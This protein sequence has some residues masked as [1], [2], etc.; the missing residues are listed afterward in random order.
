[1]TIAIIIVCGTLL[2]VISEILRKNYENKHK[3]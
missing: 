1:M 3:P 2:V